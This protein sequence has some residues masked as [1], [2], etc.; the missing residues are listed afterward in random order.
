MRTE[1][2]HPENTLIKAD[3]VIKDDIV[4]G[5]DVTTHALRIMGNG[6]LIVP[7]PDFEHPSRCVGV[8]KCRKEK[9]VIVDQALMA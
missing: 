6:V 2:H 7:R 9:I 5:D 3:N 4:K 8:F 1:G